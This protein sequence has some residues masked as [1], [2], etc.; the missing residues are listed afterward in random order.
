MDSSCKLAS[1]ETSSTKRFSRV[2]KKHREYFYSTPLSWYNIYSDYSYLRQG[3]YAFARVCV[4]GQDRAVEVGFKN[5]FGV[6]KKKLKISQ[7]PNFRFLKPKTTSQKSAFLFIFNVFFT[8]VNNVIQ[9][10]VKYE[11][12]FVAFTWPNLCLWVVILRPAFVS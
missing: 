8:C 7:S 2:S 1:A 4:C 11:L 3:G 6:L 12:R 10:I 5:R 9:M